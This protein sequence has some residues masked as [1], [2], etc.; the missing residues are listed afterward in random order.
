[1]LRI[2][3]TLF[4]GIM[5]CAFLLAC[6]KEYSAENGD[7][8]GGSGGGGGSSS[9]T[10]VFSLEGAPGSC[11]NPVINGNFVAGTPLTATNV[12]IVSVNVTTVGTYTISSGTANGISF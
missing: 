3:K 9:G 8:T 6:E 10:A 2:V 11:S 5:M 4:C 12:V 7:P 1:M